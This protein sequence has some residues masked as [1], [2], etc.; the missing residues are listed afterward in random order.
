M[1]FL[2]ST[3]T[4]LQVA[5]PS[6]KTKFT[7]FYCSCL[8]FLAG[9]QNER[10]REKRISN[11]KIPRIPYTIVSVQC[12]DRSSLF[13]LLDDFLPDLRCEVG[14]EKNVFYFKFTTERTCVD[15]YEFIKQKYL[16][17][18]LNRHD[19]GRIN[20]VDIVLF[21][22]DIRE[23]TDKLPVVNIPCEE[24]V[25][26]VNIIVN[27]DEPK[28]PVVSE[29]VSVNLLDEFYYLDYREF[30]GSGWYLK[31]TPEDEYTQDYDDRIYRSDLNMFELKWELG[32]FY[33]LAA[34]V[35]KLRHQHYMT[36]Q[37]RDVYYEVGRPEYE[38]DSF[39]FVLY[40][41]TFG[42][43]TN[44]SNYDGEN[45]KSFVFRETRDL[46]IDLRYFRY[47]EVVFEDPVNMEHGDERYDSNSHGDIKHEADYVN[48]E[49]RI[50]NKVFWGY[51]KKKVEKLTISKELFR[52]ILSPANFHVSDS[53]EVNSERMKRAA[54]TS[55][56]V[57]ISKKF[58]DR[59]QNVN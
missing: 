10:Q 7:Q 23:A 27:I 40:Y 32:E 44:L 36:F 58:T 15:F 19:N 57:N 11:P 3:A 4:I 26:S 39:P 37:G 1:P 13:E 29:D 45:L 31:F 12:D 55:G 18:R 5:T 48:V 59:G 6:V 47:D 22:V 42:Y 51:Y 49:V 25:Q 17:C 28:A 43:T 56:S 20:Y 30:Y 38:G 8:T 53:L 35:R 16:S 50:W 14:V 54:R 34:E 21:N 2:A 46:S 52:H 33:T 9:N 41:P 24:N